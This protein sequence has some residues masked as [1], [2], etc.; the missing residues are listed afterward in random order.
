MI[1]KTKIIRILKIILNKDRQLHDEIMEELGY[2]VIKT[3]TTSGFKIANRNR[4]W[5]KLRL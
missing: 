4:A 2:P 1:S 3:T 5:H